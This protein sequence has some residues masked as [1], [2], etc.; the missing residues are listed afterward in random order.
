VKSNGTICPFLLK[1]ISNPWQNWNKFEIFRNQSANSSKGFFQIYKMKIAWLY[2]F[3]LFSGVCIHSC[4]SSHSIYQVALLNKKKLTF[5]SWDGF[6]VPSISILS[7]PFFLWI[8][9]KYLEHIPD[10]LPILLATIR[11]CLGCL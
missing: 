8:R 4:V 10:A 5:L 11:C 2:F 1:N 7:V 3:F 9:S 6:L